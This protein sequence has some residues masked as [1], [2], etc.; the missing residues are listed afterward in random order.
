MADSSDGRSVPHF[1]TLDDLRLNGEQWDRY[2][3][4]V[5]GQRP[6]PM[7]YEAIRC[8]NWWG[9]G[10]PWA[11]L[12]AIAKLDGI[13]VAWVPP[14]SVLRRLLDAD[15]HEA[16]LDVLADEEETIRSAC[17]EALACCNDPWMREMRTVGQ[18]VISAW[19]GDH[20]EAAA[21]LALAGAEDAMFSA[22]RVKREKKYKGLK[23]QSRN[24]PSGWFPKSQA[25]IAPLE[26]LYTQYFPERNDPIPHTLSR[27]A[28]FH[29]LSLEHLN[30]GHCIAAIML[31]IS[32]LRELQE[33]CE[34]VRAD[35]WQT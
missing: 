19:R 14:A 26:M 13:P 7:S 24:P 2:N 12:Q 18:K 33:T 27:H 32:T 20:R 25:V 28:V 6:M 35:E 10:V 4:A 16:R 30:T 22:A 5:D 23:E 1:R 21:C 29:R 15:G 9:T 31:L 17:D 3:A 11:D 8:P 34:Q